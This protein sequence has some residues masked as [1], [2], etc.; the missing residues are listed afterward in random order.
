MTSMFACSNGITSIDSLHNRVLWTFALTVES[1]STVRGVPLSS[2]LPPL[3]KGQEKW[4]IVRAI[5]PGSE[6]FSWILLPRDM[7]FFRFELVYVWLCFGRHFGLLLTKLIVISSYILTLF[8][9]I[10]HN[11]FITSLFHWLQRFGVSVIVNVVVFI[12]K[13][14][15]SWLSAM[16]Y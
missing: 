8:Q 13:I 9:K 2:E 1:I 3:N 6:W 4:D 10:N 14:A 7:L 12:T 16:V 5:L 15:S 11:Y